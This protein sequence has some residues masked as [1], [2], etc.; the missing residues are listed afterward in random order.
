MFIFLSTLL[1]VC[2]PNTSNIL[3]SMH[4]MYMQFR[5][6][7][8]HFKEFEP[9]WC[10][11]HANLKNNKNNEVIIV[12]FNKSLKYGIICYYLHLNV[13]RYLVFGKLCISTFVWNCQFWLRGSFR[14][15]IWLV[16][17]KWKVSCMVFKQLIIS[18][19][20]KM[21]LVGCKCII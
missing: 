2:D 9:T 1:S 3:Q 8:K 5:Y 7:A 11:K 17:E 10:R 19:T 4:I 21:M 12:T 14:V 15:N 16:V 18:F 20:E 13:H 6:S